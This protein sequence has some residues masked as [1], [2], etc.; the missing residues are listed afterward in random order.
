MKSNKKILL[1]R[2]LPKSNIKLGGRELLD[3]LIHENLK[4]IFQKNFCIYGLKKKNKSLKNKLLSMLGYLDGVS[5]IEIKK[6]LKIIKVNKINNIFLSGSNL[7]KIAEIIK[8][9]FPKIKIIIFFHNVEVKFFLDSFKIMK[10]IKSFLVLLA[11]FIV[12][13]KSVN[14]SDFR[15]CLTKKDSNFLKLIYGKGANFIIPLAIKDRLLFEKIYRKKINHNNSILFVGS[16]FY[17]N[18]H[19]IKWFIENVLPKIKL[20][21]IVIGHNLDELN[22]Y[23]FKNLEIKS[24]VKKLYHWYK[25]ARFIISPIFYGSGMKTKVAEALMYGKYII[26]TSN[27]FVGYENN[28]KKIGILSNTAEEFKNN[29]QKLNKKDIK[30]F[31]KDLR[32]I[33]LENYSHTAQKKLLNNFFIKFNML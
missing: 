24:N 13:K 11:N 32:K 20:K 5:P 7:G 10:D 33:Y 18:L 31:G 27:T 6:I 3:N 25:E 4:N 30:V 12:E 22:N 17:G 23:K 21:L 1:I 16:N 19:G 29:I 8:I 9:N 2:L 15:I 14:N 28:I 26:G